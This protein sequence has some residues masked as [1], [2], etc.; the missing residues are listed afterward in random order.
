MIR[1]EVII[2]RFVRNNVPSIVLLGGLVLGLSACGDDEFV[3]VTPPAIPAGVASITGDGAVFVRWIPNKEHDLAGYRVW[4]D[5][6]L[7]EEFEELAKIKPFEDG[8]YQDNGTPTASD[9]FLEYADFLG[10]E[11]NGTLNSYAISAFDDFGNESG[12]SWEY[13]VDVPR[14][15]GSGLRLEDRNSFPLLSGYDLA[16]LSSQAQAWNAPGTDFWFESDATQ[17][18]RIA[19]PQGQVRI[20]DAGFHGFDGFGGLDGVD[21]APEFGWSATGLLEAIV[22]HTYVLR[23]RNGPSFGKEDF[24]AKVWLEGFVSGGAMFWWAFQEVPGE[25]QFSTT[26]PGSDQQPQSVSLEPGSF[27]SVSFEEVR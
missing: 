13:V 17:V 14:P 25:R 4:W 1:N 19:V 2:P 6:D 7:D 8:V 5:G 10:L 3:D 22:G 20:L 15:E 23:I 16:A 9:D 24:Y 21:I 11:F 27:E 26:G 18:A 12:L